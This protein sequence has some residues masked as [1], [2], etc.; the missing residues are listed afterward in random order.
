MTFHYDPFQGRNNLRDG[1]IKLK[2]N[3][4]KSSQFMT[5]S[6]GIIFQR[7]RYT[8][9]LRSGSNGVRDVLASAFP[10]DL[11]TSNIKFLA[12]DVE[13]YCENA[14]RESL[15]ERVVNDEDPHFCFGVPPL[16]PSLEK[17]AL[18]LECKKEPDWL[19]ADF[20]RRMLEEYTIDPRPHFNILALKQARKDKSDGWYKIII[21]AEY[22]AWNCGVQDRKNKLRHRKLCEEEH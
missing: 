2:Y 15:F 10:G 22:E 9:F 3:D 11:K 16:L 18:L 4:D 1:K 20:E 7:D 17:L 8:I 6:Q 19:R 13:M 14:E 12:M 5:P 21:T